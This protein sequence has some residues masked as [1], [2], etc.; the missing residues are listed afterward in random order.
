[1]QFQKKSLAVAVS[2]AIAP[3]AALAAPTISW[4]APS[5]GANLYGA[6]SESKV[7]CEVSGSGFNR[8]KFY[9]DTREMNSDSSSPWRCVIDTRNFSLG[10]HTLKALAIGTDGTTTSITRSVNFTSSS[11]RTTTPP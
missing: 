4:V 10:T 7:G 3:L 8:V 9:V 6:Y 5:T 1:M 11:T 2:L